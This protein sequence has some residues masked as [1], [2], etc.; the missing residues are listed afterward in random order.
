[1]PYRRKSTIG[2]VELFLL[3]LNKGTHVP[4]CI[5]MCQIEHAVVQG[6]EASQRNKLEF[7]PH[8]PPLSLKTS[9]RGIVQ[10]FLPVKRWR[11]IVGQHFV[12][13]LTTIRLSE[14]FGVVQIRR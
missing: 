8:C 11:T 13:K 9:N 12:W 10:I 3:K 1:M 4:A 5:A 6:V 2:G 7:I 14:F